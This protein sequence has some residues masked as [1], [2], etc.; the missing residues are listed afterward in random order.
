MKDARLSGKSR[1]VSALRILMLDIFAEIDYT[2]HEAKIVA[3]LGDWHPMCLN[4]S[5]L[6][7]TALHKPDWNSRASR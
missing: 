3:D 1:A 7:Q 5:L 6:F 2:I 4:D